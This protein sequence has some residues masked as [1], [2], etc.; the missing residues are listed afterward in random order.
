M[1]QKLPIKTGDQVTL[2]ALKMDMYPHTKLTQIGK[3]MRGYDPR[4]A[5]G[6][7]RL[8]C[9]EGTFDARDGRCLSGDLRYRMDINSNR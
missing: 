4:K 6:Y 7:D 3:V 9:K 5:E 1:N 8:I 2:T